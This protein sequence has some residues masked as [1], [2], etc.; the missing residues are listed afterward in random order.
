[1]IYRMKQ[2]AVGLAN[3][4][5]LSTAVLVL[6][7]T[8][9]CMFIGVEDALANRYPTDIYLESKY[10]PT[11]SINKEGIEQEVRSVID[12]Q[13]RKTGNYEKYSYLS[14]V[15]EKDQ[16]SY[17]N[18]GNYLSSKKDIPL[19]IIT[20]NQYN[21]LSG[22]KISLGRN[23]VLRY[24]K[25]DTGHKTIWLFKEEYQIKQE[26]KE[27]CVREKYTSW[28]VDTD[29]IVVSDEEVMK[30]IFHQQEE[31]YGDDA[32]KM[33]FQISFNMDGTEDQ[34]KSCGYELYTM[35]SDFSYSIKSK[36][37]AREEFFVLYGGLLFLGL[38][39][40]SLFL[41]ATVLIIY[42]KQ[43]IEGFE[44]KERFLI[45][46]NVGMSKEEVRKSI[47]S[48]V[49]SVFFI[50]IVMALIHIVVAFPILVKLLAMLN[51]TN[52]NL[53]VICTIVTILVFIVAYVIVYL[54]TARVYYRI[55]NQK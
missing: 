2:N 16:N 21:Q 14:I 31:L 12:K 34:K 9:V 53:F 5:L 25:Q 6:V 15:C 55:V 23:E 41:M 47:S 52:V 24:S 42:Y 35:K 43:V 37:L 27:I 3:I 36:Q 32:S 7:S 28:L 33:V 51:L 44:D 38:F 54:L 22:K 30:K 19:M 8:T 39:L 17:D 18:G 46:Q 10:S 45:M 40:G 50:P 4:C 29:F 20:A 11:D 26:L 1:M 48:Q 49:L 13:G